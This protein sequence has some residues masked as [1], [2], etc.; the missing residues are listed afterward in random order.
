MT[1]THLAAVGLVGILATLAGKPAAAQ[2]GARYIATDV[3]KAQLFTPAPDVPVAPMIVPQTNAPPAGNFAD[4]T[5]PLTAPSATAPPRTGATAEPTSPLTA[6]GSPPSSP[7]GAPPPR[8]Q[9]ARLPQAAPPLP[10]ST[11]PPSSTSP[12]S[13]APSS[14][15]FIP[16]QRTVPAAIASATDPSPLAE[17]FYRTYL[18]LRT[19]GVPTAAQRARLRPFLAPALDAAL[20]AAEQAEKTYKAKHNGTVPPLVEGDLFASLFEGAT[21]FIVQECSDRPPGPPQAGMP[22]PSMQCHLQLTHTNPTTNQKIEWRDTLLL[23]R[24]G[25]AWR[26]NDIVYGGKFAFGQTGQLTDLIQIVIKEAKEAKE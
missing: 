21:A 16:G 14:S 8:P 6:P 20:A 7:T 13:A 11:P 26:I 2:Y 25:N 23:I 4:P 5:S 10:S 1:L 17:A 15:Y 18:Q 9:A 3:P 22:P 12:S 24:L 19:P